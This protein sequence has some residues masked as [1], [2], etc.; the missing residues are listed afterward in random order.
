MSVYPGK[1]KNQ[2][3]TKDTKCHEGIIGPGFPSC[4]FVPFVLG[5][6]KLSCYQIGGSVLNSSATKGTK[7]HEGGCYSVSSC[8]FVSFVMKLGHY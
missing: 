8:I 6:L 1:V 2:W 7:V 5:V 4:E 3:T